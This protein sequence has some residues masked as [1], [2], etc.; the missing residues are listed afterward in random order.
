MDKHVQQA[1]DDLEEF[2]GSPYSATQRGL[3]AVAAAVDRLAAKFPQQP[4]PDTFGID[5]LL[6][7]RADLARLHKCA[8]TFLKKQTAVNF[9]ELNSLLTELAVKY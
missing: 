9:C 3:L 2:H 1:H 4:E 7:T 8:H 5:S 6:Q